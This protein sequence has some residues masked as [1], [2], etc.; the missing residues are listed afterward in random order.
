MQ[1]AFDKRTP[2]I[3][4]RSA[5]IFQIVRELGSLTLKLR[6]AP[7]CECV[8][9]DQC[10][11]LGYSRGEITTEAKKSELGRPGPCALADR[12]GLMVNVAPRGASLGVSSVIFLMLKLHSHITQPKEDKSTSHLPCLFNTVFHTLL[13]SWAPYFYRWRIDLHTDTPHILDRSTRPDTLTPLNTTC[14]MLLILTHPRNPVFLK[15]SSQV[16]K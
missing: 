2:P 6:R 9:M 13:I 15:S 8:R 10:Q 5:T 14:F 11:G 16:I 3:W 1:A 12:P 7:A 4:S